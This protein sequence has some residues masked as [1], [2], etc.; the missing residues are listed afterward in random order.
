MLKSVQYFIA[1]VFLKKEPPP[2]WQGEEMAA[3]TT[4]SG[5][6]AAL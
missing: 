2:Q 6:M 1:D 5:E 3:V 4:G